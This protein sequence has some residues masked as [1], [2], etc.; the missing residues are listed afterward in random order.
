MDSA[1][2][3]PRPPFLY[4]QSST[5]FKSR[6]SACVS[7]FQC[8]CERA[9]HFQHKHNP[10]VFAKAEANRPF[11]G[12]TDTGGGELGASRPP[13]PCPNL[14]EG[15]GR[16][17]QQHPED[18]VPSGEPLYGEHRASCCVGD[19]G[20]CVCPHNSLGKWMYGVSF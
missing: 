7:H 11:L 17:S 18:T 20:S 8:K 1:V 13:Q 2:L 5:V 9:F 4:T 3:F 19:G 10:G 14:C 12:H 6:V 16:G 15:E